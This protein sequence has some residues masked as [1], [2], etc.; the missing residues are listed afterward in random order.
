MAKRQIRIDKN[1]LEQFASGDVFLTIILSNQAVHLVKIHSVKSATVKVKN[2]KGHVL[3]LPL[4]QIEMIWLE[5][6]VT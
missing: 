3:H 6:K 5:E 2:T 4:E 1:K